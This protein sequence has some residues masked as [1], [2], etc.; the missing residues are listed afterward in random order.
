MKI[1]KGGEN[2]GADFLGSTDRIQVNTGELSEVVPF[3]ASSVRVG[4]LANEID[5]IFG[6]SLPCKID[7][8]GYQLNVDEFANVG[9]VR[10]AKDLCFTLQLQSGEETILVTDDLSMMVEFVGQYLM[11]RAEGSTNETLQ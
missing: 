11:A 6:L 4:Q 9:Q 1:D 3:P 7:D 8:L 10:G 2:R 5:R